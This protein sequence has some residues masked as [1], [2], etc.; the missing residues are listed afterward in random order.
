MDSVS[1]SPDPNRLQAYDSEA[2][3]FV[4]RRLAQIDPE[5]KEL[6]LTPR[7]AVTPDARNCEKLAWLGDAIVRSAVTKMIYTTF[8]DDSL[9]LQNVGPLNSNTPRG[10]ADV[11]VIGNTRRFGQ[12]APPSSTS[13]RAWLNSLRPPQSLRKR[14]DSQVEGRPLRGDCRC[15]P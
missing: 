15:N 9:K 12:R 4:S 11:L 7:D 5:L 2:R 3:E 6:A 14:P 1:H 13:G 8:Q 10:L